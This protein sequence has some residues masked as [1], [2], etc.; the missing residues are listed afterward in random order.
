MPLMDGEALHH[1]APGP[2]R[3]EVL[4]AGHNDMVGSRWIEAIADWVR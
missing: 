2:K 1:A 4:D 3:I